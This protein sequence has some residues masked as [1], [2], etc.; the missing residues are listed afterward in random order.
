MMELA[1]LKRGDLVNVE[2]H[3]G[4]VITL[5]PM[6]RNIEPK[7]AAATAE[8]T[9]NPQECPTFSN[10]CHEGAAGSSTVEAVLAISAEVL[11]AHGGAGGV[12][13]Q[14]LL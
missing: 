7:T 2:V 11:S 10:A 5:T 9:A 1:R 8:S 13:N 14:T 6:R 3:E 4:S 12:R